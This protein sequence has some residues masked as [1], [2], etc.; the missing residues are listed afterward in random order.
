MGVPNLAGPRN[1]KWRGGKT[2]TKKG[3]IQFNH[4]EHRNKYEHRVIIEKLIRSRTGGLVW[5]NQIQIPENMTVHHN[6]HR[7]AHNCNDNLML[8]EKAIHDY[9]SICDARRKAE[10][11]LHG[12]EEPPF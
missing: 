9:L 2:F 5:I 11:E 3:Y 10:R 12:D 1:G 6:D 7:R 8:L 4:G